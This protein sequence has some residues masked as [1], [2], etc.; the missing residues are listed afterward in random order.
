[1][2]TPR[3][4]TILIVDDLDSILTM[5][6]KQLMAQGHTV[7]TASSADEALH[8]VRQLHGQLDLILSDVVMPGMNGTEL[9]AII[10]TEF[11]GLPIVLMS[12]YVAA[13]MTRVGFGESIIPVLQKPFED[14]Q[15][16]ELIEAAFELSTRRRS[17]HPAA[18]L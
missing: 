7:L 8:H 16:A 10:T 3:R 18:A 15:L 14:H 12:A 6:R 4:G 2:P 13:G 11:P 5:L 1:M 17:S 9:A